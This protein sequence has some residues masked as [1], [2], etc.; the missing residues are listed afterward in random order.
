M[1]D[2]GITKTTL[3]G[4]VYPGG[5]KE[6]F[7][8]ALIAPTLSVGT[9]SLG[10]AGVTVQSVPVQDVSYVM[11]LP[12]NGPWQ[13]RVSASNI[14]VK[15]ASQ[16]ILE[17]V[18]IPVEDEEA[19]ELTLHVRGIPT[20]S[21]FADLVETHEDVHVADIQTAINQ[22][23]EPWDARLSHFRNHG[24]QFEGMSVETAT[25][26]LYEAAGGTPREIADRFVDTLRHM[27]N[28]FHNTDAGKAPTIVAMARSGPAEDSVLTVYLKHRAGL[29]GLHEQKQAAAEE[30]RRRDEAQLQHG[31]SRSLARPVVGSINNGGG[32]NSFINDDML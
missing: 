26:R 3:N 15:I 18:G 19:G 32:G 4:A 1:V 9:G 14:K 21:I 11:E 2:Y 8:S 16:P 13:L 23:L 29:I 31:L 7:V 5:S 10:G 30:Q 28:V 25:R 6:N 17:G 24:T 20:D 12:T 22:I 27:G